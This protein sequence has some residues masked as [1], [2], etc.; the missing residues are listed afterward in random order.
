MAAYCWFGCSSDTSCF[1]VH[2]YISLVLSISKGSHLKIGTSNFGHVGVA[3]PMSNLY[4]F[5]HSTDKLADLQTKFHIVQAE[6]HMP[7]SLVSMFHCFTVSLFHCFTSLLFHCFTVSLLHCYAVSLLHCFTVSL[8]HC[9]TVTLFHC[10]T[11]SL[12][13][14]FTV[15]LSHCFTVSL[16]ALMDTHLW[17]A[18]GNVAGQ[19][20]KCR[21]G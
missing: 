3:M 5:A 12:F 21:G 11:V 8:L 14:C 4:V 18:V 1:G 10:F 6:L 7:A 19:Y 16:Y 9:Y 17:H 2:K 15:S 13:H 20:R